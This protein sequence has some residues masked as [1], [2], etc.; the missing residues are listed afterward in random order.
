MAEY[1][2]GR[3][4]NRT[5]LWKVVPRTVPFAIGLTPSDFCNFRCVYCNQSTEAGIKDAKT[6]TWGEFMEQ[7][8]QIEELLEKGTDDL[9]V[10]TIH[11]NGEPLIHPQIADMV[12]ECAKR[13]LAPRIEI[14]TNGSL[15]THELSD[16]LIEAGLTKLLVSV[17]GTTPE[18]Y[19]EICGYQINDF[20]DYVE[21][22][23]YFHKKSGS[24][25]VYVKTLNIALEGDEDRKR[26]L[27]LFSP[28]CD[29]IYVE[30]VMRACDDVK[31][32]EMAWGGVI[33]KTTRFG[34]KLTKMECCNTLFMYLNIHSNG[35]ADCCGCKY[36]PLY[37]GNIYKTPMKNL[38]NGDVHRKFMKMH[39]Q[40]QRDHISCCRHCE[41]EHYSGFVEDILDG[42]RKEI[43]ERVERMGG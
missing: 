15:L 30:N 28:V 40:G 35:D 25:R 20:E 29:E 32:D 38:W 18:K 21:Q 41:I 7:V 31:Y 9:K 42:H 24:C 6:T 5:M 19:R 23:D 3:D 22:I 2:P 12:R 4:T 14:T 33:D 36:P 27:D 39:L 8:H 11:G 1:K 17:Q 43:L 37:I 10:I 16:A 34:T 26:F 13:R